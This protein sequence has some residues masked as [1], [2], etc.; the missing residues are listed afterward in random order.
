MAG[1]VVAVTG[2][3]AS[4]KSEVADRF[5]QLGVAVVDADQAARDIVE[6]GQPALAEIL[7]RFGP[8]MA[9]ADGR[10]D[11][12]ALRNLV[13]ADA[14]ARRDLE[15]IT[16]P[17]IRTRLCAQCQRAPGDY[18][19]AAIPLLVEGGGRTAYPWLQRILVV[20]T[21]AALQLRRL[22]ARDGADAALA[23]RMIAAQ[24]SRA[25]RLAIAD[26]VIVNDGAKSGLA[27]IVAA[28]DARYR[29][30]AG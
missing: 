5:A 6:P 14:L 9:G 24:A 15:A 2:G 29:R 11:R 25:D 19:I 12:P 22:Q 13:F 3:I 8:Q 30:L 7:E 20:D 21:P 10:L 26:D 23:E 16:H 18:A 27:P 17:R 4:G 28:L 1:Y